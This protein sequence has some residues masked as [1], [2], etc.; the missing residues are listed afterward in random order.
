MNEPLHWVKETKLNVYLNLLYTPKYFNIRNYHRDLQSKIMQMNTDH[1]HAAPN[2]FI[3][4]EDYE[5]LDG[6]LC[7]VKFSDQQRGEN[8]DQIFSELSTELR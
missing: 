2:E 7:N 1:L 5:L 3:I 6:F 4:Q 8:F